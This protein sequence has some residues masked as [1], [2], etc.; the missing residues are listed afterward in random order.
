LYWPSQSPDRN[1]IETLWLDLKHAV[2]ARIL[3]NR[4]QLAEF[5]KEE[6]AADVRDWSVVT[7]DVW[8][9]EWLQKE[10]P[11]V[12]VHTFARNFQFL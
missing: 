4:S 3:S 11:Q 12:S 10:V 6:W 7:E 5:C 1:P 2:H 9:K 8:L